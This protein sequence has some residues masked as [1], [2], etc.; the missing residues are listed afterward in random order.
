MR[1][2][3]ART[4]SPSE[5]WQSVGGLARNPLATLRDRELADIGKKLQ[6]QRG[7][8]Y[9]PL[10]DGQQVGG[11]YRQSINSPAVALPLDNGIGF[12]F[13][14]MATFTGEEVGSRDFWFCSRGDHVLGY[15]GATNTWC[16]PCTAPGAPSTERHVPNTSWCTT[17][18][19]S[20]PQHRCDGDRSSH[21]NS[22]TQHKFSENRVRAR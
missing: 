11:V 16:G 7:E 1:C 4:L 5:A 21:F 19:R 20:P 2:S 17:A 3:P 18:W 8:T 10:Q 6:D 14:A 15:P 12:S 9:R 13:G 22:A